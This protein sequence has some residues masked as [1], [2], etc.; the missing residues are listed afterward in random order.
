MK[1][2]VNTL[3]LRSPGSP[4]PGLIKKKV[5]VKGKT[6]HYYA[7]RWVSTS[8]LAP[9]KKETTADK[10]IE[11]IKRNYKKIDVELDIT[12]YNFFILNTVATFKK[13]KTPDRLPDTV[14][15]SGSK[16]WY[17]KKG[18]YRE[19]DHWGTGIAGN[20]WYIEG[21][22]G[23]KAERGK[24]SWDYHYGNAVGYADWN[25]FKSARYSKKNLNYVLEKAKSDYEDLKIRIK[26]R[27]DKEYN[28][29]IQQYK[30]YKNRI[31]REKK[32]RLYY[33]KKEK[34]ILK[35]LE[36]NGPAFISRGHITELYT[37]DLVPNKVFIKYRA[38]L[39]V[40]PKIGGSMEVR[41]GLQGK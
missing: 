36:L 10:K 25:D 33:D 29:G 19:S 6:G 2:I 21:P 15:K 40:S 35:R 31:S 30:G 7:Y 39:A 16:Y 3:F 38:A 1:Y 18:V 28:L 20:S 37:L 41:E 26:D 13:T 34:I 32:V 14:S 8:D 9:T 4:R 27:F 12:R 11:N 17:T 24:S 22:R 23:G 5:N